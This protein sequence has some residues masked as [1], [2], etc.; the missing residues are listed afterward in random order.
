M[1]STRDIIK[2]KTSGMDLQDIDIDLAMEEVEVA[3][4]N[5]CNRN[6]IPARARFLLANLAVDLLK[7]Q[8]A[9][10]G[11]D[12]SDIPAGELGSITVDDVSLSFDA[13]KRSHVVNLDD[14]LLNYREQLNQFR[15]MR[16]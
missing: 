15:K 14:I 3:F 11:N 9:A 1:T 6:D 2:A 4:K 16:W 13:S 5:Y 7:S 12:G 8:H 10:D